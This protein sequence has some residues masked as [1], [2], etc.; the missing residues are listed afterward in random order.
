MDARVEQEALFEPDQLLAGGLN[1][2][3]SARGK[4]VVGCGRCTRAA[5]SRRISS[6]RRH[7]G[8]VEPQIAALNCR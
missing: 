1:R 8:A 4:A 2:N 7:C 3:T 5:H 6:A